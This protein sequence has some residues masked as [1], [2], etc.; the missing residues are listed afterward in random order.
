MKHS[1]A[2]R[3]PVCGAPVEATP[4]RCPR[5]ETVHHEDC[6]TYF[7]G[8][9]IFGCRDGHAPDAI[10]VRT[11]PEGFHLLTEYINL[12]R[13]K[14]FVIQGAVG[15]L[16]AGYL[17][18]FVAPALGSI[19]MLFFPLALLYVGLETRAVWIQWC[20]KRHLGAQARET[21]EVPASRLRTL[22]QHGQGGSR[23]RGMLFTG[24]LVTAA[25]IAC[26]LM[27]LPR[28]GIFL[29][30][31]GALL[32]AMGEHLRVHRAQYDLLCHRARATWQPV[33][34]EKEKVEEDGEV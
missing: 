24:G 10:E 8:C 12:F 30:I 6:A 14:S 1:A 19:A 31:P 25:S 9:A 15:S 32:L 18:A 4:W 21:F 27:R 23:S 17:L 33:M 22:I 20:L 3:C 7:G 34:I 26:L 2:R 29:I 28:P 16:L 11:W 13:W 5:C